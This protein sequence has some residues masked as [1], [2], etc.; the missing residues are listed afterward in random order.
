MEKINLQ[1]SRK[2]IVAPTPEQYK[3]QLIAKTEHVIKR[4]RWKIIEFE[5][6]LSEQTKETYGFRS[7][8]SPPS[9]PG[10]VKFEDDL[11]L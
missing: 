7:R 10:L 8:K 2:N 1:Y 6:K 3:L 4:M 11:K 9:Q 5:G